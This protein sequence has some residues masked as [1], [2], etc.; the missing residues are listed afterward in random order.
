[1]KWNVSLCT[2]VWRNI[3]WVITT[4]RTSGS[5]PTIATFKV[6]WFIFWYCYRHSLL[7]L[8]WKHTRL[9]F[10]SVNSGRQSLR[11]NSFILER[12][13][14]RRRDV[15][16]SL[17]CFSFLLNILFYKW[18]LICKFCDHRF[19]LLC[20][21]SVCKFDASTAA[22]QQRQRTYLGDNIR[23]KNGTYF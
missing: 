15:I 9:F 10:S 5:R 12:C 13:Y 8:T 16:S 19:F 3:T 17:L 11:Y 14:S 23:W 6:A 22:R 2:M 4:T 7:T 21:D 1:M 20:F 18:L